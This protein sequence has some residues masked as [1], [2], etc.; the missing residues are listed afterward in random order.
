VHAAAAG[1]VTVNRVVDPPEPS[2]VS[3]PGVAMVATPPRVDA[4]APWPV[5][6]NNAPAAMTTIAVR[7][8]QRI[9]RAF[10]LAKRR[11]LGCMADC[12]SS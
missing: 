12:L 4:V 9:E 2:A 5:T 1:N 10:V 6:A 8:T 7:R 11:F 3:V